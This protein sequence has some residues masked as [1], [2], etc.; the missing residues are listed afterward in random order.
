MP[1]ACFGDRISLAWD[2]W[3]NSRSF[4]VETMSQNRTI[5]DDS[6]S[7]E[8]NDAS[9]LETQPTETGAEQTTSP[10]S[11]RQ[12]APDDSSSDD[13]DAGSNLDT[14]PA[15]TTKEPPSASAT[16]SERNLFDDDSSSDNE[17]GDTPRPGDAKKVAKSSG[18]E[19]EA[20]QNPPNE[21]SDSSH[22]EK[23]NE[24]D[25]KESPTGQGQPKNS[26]QQDPA[27]S[28]RLVIGDSDEEDDGDAEFDDKGAVVG[29]AAPEK[30]AGVGDAGG[31]ATA[32]LMQGQEGALDAT[33]GIPKQDPKLPQRATVLD[34]DRPAEGVSLHMTKLPNI[35]AIQ[36]E[37]F[38]QATYDAG[39]EE[40]QYRGY[41]HNMIRWRYKE[42]SNGEKM[43]D[44]EGNLVRESNS[45]IVKWEDGSY[46]L[47]IGNEAFE[48][49]AL[50]SAQSG[51]A[52]LNGYIY[53]SQNATFKT[54]SKDDE[55]GEGTAGGTV[56]ECM[57]S[58]A[59]RLSARPSSLQSE[60]HKS[61]TV[62]IRQRTI[63]TARIAE[64]VTEEDP[65][66][67]KQERI[68][69]DK[70]EEKIQARKKS[71]FRSTSSRMRTPGMN[72]R[73]LEEEDGVYDSTSIRAL[74]RRD[75]DDEMD[76]FGDSDGDDDDYDTFRGRSSRTKRQRKEAESEDEEE[77]MVFGDDSDEDDV[78][79]VKARTKKRSHQAVLE[80]DDDD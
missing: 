73:F 27:A 75:M 24:G 23:H 76:D 19:A 30:P 63:K 11:Q 35:V 6:S 66:K 12:I 22:Q 29:S 58:V 53:L 17:D 50:D 55:D 62:A 65:E 31:A 16:S 79:Q 28:S 33:A 36:P 41:V 18:N 20:A 71:G 40:E 80:D 39:D 77:E 46:T 1:T 26:T 56:L 13:Q 60:A 3:T 44:K 54:G 15:E 45:R 57:G 4:L 10:A 52:G 38:N 7:D 43:R 32:T 47:H 42:G 72:K 48:V 51:F 9:N 59:S 2:L 78:A 61:L 14:Q 8:E 69:Y 34:V 64:Y 70:D 49:D 37:A 67:A 5:F 25:N 68:K 21:S 74:K